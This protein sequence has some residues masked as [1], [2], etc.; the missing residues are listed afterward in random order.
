MVKAK[1]ILSWL[2]LGVAMLPAPAVASAATAGKGRRSAA[3][4]RSPARSRNLWATIDICSPKDQR[5]TVGIRGSMPGDGNAQDTIMMRF[6]LQY[7]DSTTHR[8]V[9]L[10]SAASGMI[11]VGGAQVTRQ[12]GFSFGLVPR[13]GTPA[14]TLRGAVDFQWRHGK[15][16]LASVSRFTTAGHRKVEHADP[17]NFSA[18]TCRIG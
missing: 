17:P 6:R 12:G 3:S 8:W 11:A 7:M 14:Y 18:A 10:A 4:P 13:A 5:N 9:D 16:V 2:A 1:S 15:R